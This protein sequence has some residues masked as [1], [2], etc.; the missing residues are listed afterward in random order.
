VAV[1]HSLVVPDVI[2]KPSSV[3]HTDAIL[4]AHLD[5]IGAGDIVGCEVEYGTSSSYGTAVPCD[6]QLPI[7]GAADATV[8]LTNLTTEATYHFRFRASNGNGTSNGPDSVFTPHW[9]KALETGEATDIGPGAATLHGEL[10]PDGESTHYFFEWGETKAYGHS[11]PGE[12][13]A[14]TS[15]AGLTPVEASLDGLVTSATTYHYRLVGVNGLGTS[16]GSDR[17]FTT[18]L[19]ASPQIDNVTGTATGLGTATLQADINPGFGNTAY[20][21]QYGAD[22]SYGH[23]TVVAGPI[24]N[25]GTFHHVSVEISNLEPGTPYHFRV[26]AFNFSQRVTSGDARFITGSLPQ[27][28]DASAAALDPNTVRLSARLGGGGGTTTIRFEYGPSSAYGARTADSAPVGPDGAAAVTVGG[29]SPST[30]YHYRAVATNEFGQAPSR[31][32]TFTTPPVR[33]SEPPLRRAKKCKTG[34]TRRKGRCVRK[35][36]RHAKHRSG[37]GRAQ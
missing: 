15:A 19:A 14:V 1:F 23:S 11:T 32:E 25:D 13:G 3:G 22:T 35:H 16:Y 33:R 20:K 8:H 2:P 24:G 18:P 34:F 28:S 27:I 4:T 6:Q 10:N 5:P 12:P 30:T 7:T 37:G 26:I 9:V 29:L 17:E 36:R 31:D 21:F